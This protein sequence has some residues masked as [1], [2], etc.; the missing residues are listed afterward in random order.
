M[1]SPTHTSS[2]S[3]AIPATPWLTTIPQLRRY[4]SSV[5]V[6]VCDR[7]NDSRY[8]LVT[9]C[10]VEHLFIPLFSW[11]VKMFSFQ[12]NWTCWWLELAQVVRSQVL[13]GSWRRGA[14]MWR[15]GTHPAVTKSLFQFWVL[16]NQICDHGFRETEEWEERRQGKLLCKLLFQI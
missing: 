7:Y 14:P 5:M 16:L 6:C 10:T 1:K 2:T 9:R 4:W 11:E 12:G 8:N 15:Q 3:I 13:L